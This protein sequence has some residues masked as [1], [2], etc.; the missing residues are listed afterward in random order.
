MSGKY[1]EGI[2][3]NNVSESIK[4]K[5]CNQINITTI[6]L[7]ISSGHTCVT[8]DVLYLPLCPKFWIFQADN[9]P[10]SLILNYTCFPTL[11]ID[12]HDLTI[13]NTMTN[14]IVRPPGQV[15]VNWLEAA[16]LK[17]ILAQQ[18]TVFV[19]LKHQDK[20]IHF[21]VDKKPGN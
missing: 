5:Y 9:I 14:H 21:V 15:R 20:A 10:T 7:E 16:L 18:Y 8:V 4:R 2:G 12:W 13:V 11:T 1:Y 6:I 3:P 19:L 17:N